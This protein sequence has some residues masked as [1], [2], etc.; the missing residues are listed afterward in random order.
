M[1][2]VTLKSSTTSATLNPEKRQVRNTEISSL[3]IESL[4]WVSAVLS[5][6][7]GG[8]RESPIPR[9]VSYLEM[10]IRGI[11]KVGIHQIWKGNFR[12]EQ[13][14]F[15]HFGLDVSRHHQ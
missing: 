15:W 9:R 1:V 5:A 2:A 4:G 11:V 12:W 14:Q 10:T 13:M 7:S 6:K 8:F 3:T